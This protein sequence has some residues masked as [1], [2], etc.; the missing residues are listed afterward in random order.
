M[1]RPFLHGLFIGLSLVTTTVTAS[2]VI[3]GDQ[4]EVLPIEQIATQ[5][6]SYEPKTYSPKREVVTQE[7]LLKKW[8]TIENAIFNLKKLDAAEQETLRDIALQDMQ[9]QHAKLAQQK[10][11]AKADAITRDIGYDIELHKVTNDPEKIIERRKIDETINRAQTTPLFEPTVNMDSQLFDPELDSLI[12][13]NTMVNRPTALSFFD[14]M[15]NP[16]PILKTIPNATEQSPFAYETINENILIIS[17]NE[18]YKT[19]SGFI[20]LKTINQPIPIRYTSDPTKRVDVKRNIQI[21]QTSPTADVSIQNAMLTFSDVKKDNDPA[22]FSFLSGRSVGGSKR[23]K[24]DGLPTRS[25]AWRYKKHVY[26][27][28]TATMKY[29]VLGAKSS[30]DWKIFKAYPRESYWF[31]IDGTDREVFVMDNAYTDGV[32][33]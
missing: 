27:K 9:R 33:P 18:H 6:Q 28:S 4:G 17:A 13:V 22:M 29:D 10:F 31:S 1:S 23:I 25:Q 2:V 19:V 5:T 16:F 24:I 30:G 8:G 3:V 15:G 7:Q 11:E 12:T 26:I 14:Q 32:T 21:P 20:F